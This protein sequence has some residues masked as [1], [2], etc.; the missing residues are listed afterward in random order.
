MVGQQAWSYLLRLL[1]CHMFAWSRGDSHKPPHPSTSDDWF[2][3]LTM[4]LA[5]V[6]QIQ[7]IVVCLS[8]EWFKPVNHELLY[9]LVVSVCCA[10][11]PALRLHDAADTQQ[12][13]TKRAAAGRGRRKDKRLS[14]TLQQQDSDSELVLAK[15]TPTTFLFNVTSGKEII[16]LVKFCLVR[17]CF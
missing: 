16:F 17:T 8:A 4:A 1:S 2:H 5:S 6:Q 15:R 12:Q 3:R 7:G 9:G 11:I 10:V 13:G 14:Q